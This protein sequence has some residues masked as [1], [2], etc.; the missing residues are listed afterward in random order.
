MNALFQHQDYLVFH[1]TPIEIKREPDSPP[2]KF[3]RLTKFKDD[4]EEEKVD[5]LK[6][7]KSVVSAT[8]AKIEALREEEREA[9][10]KMQEVK[11]KP[12]VIA[13]VEKVKEEAD[14]SEIDPLDAYMQEV[15]KEVRK[16]NH[17]ITEPKKN[18]GVVIL[19][20]VAKKPTQRK[21]KGELLEQNMDSL[22][23]VF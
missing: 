23:L 16:G 21:N 8:E 3:L 2:S 10:A 17:I 9:E 19:T 20:G 14:D 11:E 7:S 12:Q 1:V 5:K 4:E 22:D 18:Q 13:M 15:A 6:F